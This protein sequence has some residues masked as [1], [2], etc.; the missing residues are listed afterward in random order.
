MFGV[1]VQQVQQPAGLREEGTEEE[2]PLPAVGTC[3][4]LWSSRQNR[5][6]TQHL[7]QAPAVSGGITWQ[8]GGKRE[9]ARVEGK[10]DRKREPVPSSFAAEIDGQKEKE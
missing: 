10:E 9:I 2:G 6:P 1:Y 8:H 7:L 4:C 3:V 5:T